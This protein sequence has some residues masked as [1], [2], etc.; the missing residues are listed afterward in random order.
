MLNP[1]HNLGS[2]DLSFLGVPL[3]IPL[4]QVPGLPG[5]DYPV[6]S[7]PPETS[8]VCDVQ[9]VEGYYADQEVSTLLSRSILFLSLP[10]GRLS[11]VPRLLAS[12]RRS[13]HQVR[14]PVSQRHNLQPG[15]RDLRKVLLLACQAEFVCD[16]WFNVD[17]SQADQFYD[18]NIEVAEKNARRQAEREAA[19]ERGEEEEREREE[20][21]AE[22]IEQIRNGGEVPTPSSKTAKLTIKQPSSNR[23]PKAGGRPQSKTGSRKTAT[24]KTQPRGQRFGFKKLPSTKRGPKSFRAKKVTSEQSF[25][26]TAATTKPALKKSQKSQFLSIG[27]KS[28]SRSAPTTTRPKPKP[29]KK[30]NIVKTTSKPR[31]KNADS[32]KA[33]KSKPTRRSKTKTHKSGTARKTS[34]RFSLPK[35]QPLTFGRFNHGANKKRPQRQLTISEPDFQQFELQTQA[36]ATPP[37]SISDQNIQDRADYFDQDSELRLKQFEQ[38]LQERID[39]QDTDP[40]VDQITQIDGERENQKLEEAAILAEQMR[41]D[42]QRLAQQQLLEERRKQQLEKLNN[43]IQLQ[44]ENTLKKDLAQKLEEEPDFSSK[45]A[46]E[47]EESNFLPGG[48]PKVP[49]VMKRRKVRRRRPKPSEEDLLSLNETSVSPFTK[50]G[51]GQSRFGFGG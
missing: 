16:W 11:I 21:T 9:P 43:Q 45:L 4:L 2:R 50:F 41:L 38:Q 42:E 19:K 36:L 10:S 3:I 7:S 30:Q 27:S 18:L 49:K 51:N 31:R 33:K 40:T 15:E 35:N 44:I 39:L 22:Q 26:R 29:F 1:H 6:F 25:G 5:D 17:C 24:S 12:W 23:R 8:F 48:V 37:E 34:G 28:A 47:N 46:S 32:R 20:L 13:L 14:L